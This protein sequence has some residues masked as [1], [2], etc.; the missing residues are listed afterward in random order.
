MI[1]ITWNANPN[2][3]DRHRRKIELEVLLRSIPKAYR[4]I[5]LQKE[6]STED[7]TLIEASGSI[8]L[9]DEFLTDFGETAALCA[10]VDLVISVDTSV[11]HIAGTL[12]KEVWLLLDYVPAWRW[13]NDITKTPWYPSMR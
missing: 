2:R 1:G 9:F 12:G 10:S 4:I 7:R 3:K 11:A 13:S 8:E 5:A 6:F